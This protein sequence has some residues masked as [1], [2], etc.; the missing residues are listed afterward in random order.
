MSKNRLYLDSSDK[1]NLIYKIGNN[2]KE[3]AFINYL[4]I[5]TILVFSLLVINM[6]FWLC[7]L[8]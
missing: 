5:I 6:F 4:L 2:D 7:S 8:I 3:A 1:N